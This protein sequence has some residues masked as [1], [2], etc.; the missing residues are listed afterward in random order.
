[1]NSFQNRAV[2]H[3]SH[4]S[5]LGRWCAIILFLSGC[6]TTSKLPPSQPT[7]SSSIIHPEPSVITVY[8]SAATTL[9]PMARSVDFAI[10]EQV[11]KKW[12]GVPYCYGGANT[13]CIDCSAFVQ[14]LYEEV[15]SINIPRTTSQQITEGRAVAYEEIQPG[16]LL[17]FYPSKKDQLH[18]GVALTNGYFVHAS[19]SRGVVIDAYTSAFWRNCFV[20]AR[21]LLP[22]FTAIKALRLPIKR[23]PL[24]IRGVLPPETK[25]KAK[26]L[27]PKRVGW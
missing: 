1:M 24:I 11:K 3:Y 12:L 6:A 17:F 23:K 26:P 22:D 16:D 27:K 25:N 19:T 21:R 20:T 13:Q 2:P 4:I 14:N 15:L 8:S 7:L 10:R 5:K 9:S 18:V